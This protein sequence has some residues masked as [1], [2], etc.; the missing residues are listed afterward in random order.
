MLCVRRSLLA[1]LHATSPP[2]EVLLTFFSPLKIPTFAMSAINRDVFWQLRPFAIFGFHSRSRGQLSAGLSAF[3]SLQCLVVNVCIVP[4]HRGLPMLWHRFQRT[5]RSDRRRERR[6]C[7]RIFCLG[8]R[9]I[10][11]WGRQDQSL[12]LCWPTAHT[13]MNTQNKN[14]PRYKQTHHRTL[15][16]PIL[17]SPHK[18]NHDYA[19]I[20][21]P[22]TQPSFLG[23]ITFPLIL[24]HQTVF[25][26]KHKGR[27]FGHWI[28]VHT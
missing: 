14:S 19:S 8:I 12:P 28:Y 18:K 25:K 27:L 22:M 11:G 2:I 21:I 15:F 17:M 24:I 5:S 3:A 13:H 23:N 6:A 7:R 20:L 10:V 26:L 4:W 1:W 16:V 9:A